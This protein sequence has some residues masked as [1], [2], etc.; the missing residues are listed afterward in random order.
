MISHPE[1]FSILSLLHILETST[2]YRLSLNLDSQT[3]SS[4]RFAKAFVTWNSAL[5]SLA[6]FR[7]RT[8]FQILLVFLLLTYSQDMALFA[9]SAERTQITLS[10]ILCSCWYVRYSLKVNLFCRS[11]STGSHNCWIF[12]NLMP[13]FANTRNSS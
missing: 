1:T 9:N 13:Q 8:F 5:A 4:R 2:R 3:L 12:T 6:M 7:I 11:R 10:T